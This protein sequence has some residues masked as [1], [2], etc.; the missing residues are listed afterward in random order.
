LGRSKRCGLRTEQCRHKKNKTKS[1]ASVPKNITVILG[2]P[3]ASSFY[4]SIADRYVTAAQAAGHSVKLFRL[5]EMA[6]DPVLRHGYKKRQEL[7]P[8]LVE[9]REAI[10]WAQHL[11]FVYPIWWGSI[12]ALL[13]GM[14]DRLFLPG[15]AF[16]CRKDSPWWDRLLAGRSAHAIATMDTPP[17]YYQLF[18]M[19]PGHHQMKK[20]ILEFCGFKPVRMTS[21]GPVR[22]DSE[23]QMAKWLRQIEQHA[24]AA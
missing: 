3:D 6:F 23:A 7:E 8:A 1:I 4:G 12:P 21:L 15:Y 16:K 9:I 24:A 22:H 20:T 11:V 2:H 5:G 18:Y 19:R 10:D 14:F 17:W 13:K